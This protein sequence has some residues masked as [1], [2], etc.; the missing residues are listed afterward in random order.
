MKLYF[1]H[2]PKTGGST[3]QYSLNL[4]KG[5][6]GCCVIKNAALQHCNWKDYN[7]L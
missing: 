3:V 2:I 6:Q 1:I 7:K 5:T 4:T